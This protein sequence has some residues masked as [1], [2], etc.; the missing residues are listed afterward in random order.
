MEKWQHA[1]LETLHTQHSKQ[2]STI[3]PLG[4]AFLDFEDI[5]PKRVVQALNEL[6]EEGWQLIST[7]SGTRDDGTRYTT[8]YLKRPAPTE[9][10]GGW[11]TGL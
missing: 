9:T 6:G 7:D 2:L 4:G 11:G 5:S 1:V 10:G 3:T 8:Y